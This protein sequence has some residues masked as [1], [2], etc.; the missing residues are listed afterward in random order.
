MTPKPV[1][2]NKPGTERRKRRVAPGAS[3]GRPAA[4]QTARRDTREDREHVQA[5]ERGFAVIKA[6]SAEAPALT[7]AELASRTGLTRAAARRYLLTLQKLGCVLQTGVT[8]ALTPRVLDLGFAYLSTMSLATVAEPWMENVVETL[9]ESCSVSVLD[10][11]DI[12]Y[13]ARVPAKRIMSINLVVGSRLPA[14]AT[15]MGKVLLAHLPEHELDGWLQSASLR[16]L[17]KRTIA[18]EATLRRVLRDVR[19]QGW[20]MADGESEEGVRSVAAP[21]RDR[22]GLV[23]A[24]INVSAHASRVSVQDLKRRHL[25]VLLEAARS[26]SSSFGA[27]IRR[28]TSRPGALGLD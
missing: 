5:L 16:P 23:K 27:S 6:F 25:P 2:P 9:H 3:T 20:A 13:V 17:T 1:T 15:S 10:G 4:G 11:H 24:A 14:H 8:F 21:L 18:D 28:H 26:I 22:A 19:E 7:I 12:V